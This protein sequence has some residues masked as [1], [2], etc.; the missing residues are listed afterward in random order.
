MR[1]LLIT[2]EEKKHILGLYESDLTRIVKRVISENEKSEMIDD[3]KDEIINNISKQDLMF[4]GKMYLEL[5][6][7]KFKDIV[8]DVIGDKPNEEE[9]SEISFRTNDMDKV[10]KITKLK[11]TL[12]PIFIIAAS[13]SAAAA[14]NQYN[15]EVPDESGILLYGIISAALVGAGLISKIPIK[16][17][18]VPENLKGTKI[19]KNIES[20]LDNS[21]LSH[22]TFEDV[23]RHFE[24]IG[25]PTKVSMPIISDWAEK[26]GV[27]FI[28][29]H[30][31]TPR[32]GN[33]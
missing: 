5:G 6:D 22:Q 11:Q 32:F 31:Y 20:Y 16:G 19:Q 10:D 14:F 7:D 29:K 18:R 4:L 2:E 26:N 1:R 17:K 33:G 21:D 27:S 13:L 15:R 12:E 24:T 25:V 8:K 28:K 23:V 30:K 3:V 9:L